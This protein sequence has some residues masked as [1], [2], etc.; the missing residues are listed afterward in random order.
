[1][2]NDEINNMESDESY[3]VSDFQLTTTPNDFNISTIISFIN[4]SVFKIPAFQRHYVWDIK[5][6]SKLIESLLIGLPIPQIFLY[7]N[8][9]NEFL[10]IDG[11][12]RLMTLYYFFNGRFPRKE[13]RAELRNIFDKF[14]MIPKDVM[15][16]DRYFQK[17][18]LKLESPIDGRKNRFDGLNYQTLGE[19]KL[20]LDLSTIRNMVIKPLGDDDEG[21]AKFEIFNRLNSGGMNLTPQEIRMS[22]YHSS[23]NNALLEMNTNRKWRDFLGK[24][25]EDLRLSDV[26]HILRLFAMLCHQDNYKNSISGF[27]NSFS[28]SAR[29][30]S[31]I[32]INLLKDIWNGFMHAC[33]D[34][35]EQDLTTGGNRISITLLESIFFAACKK[36]YVDK[37]VKIKDI[38]KEYVKNLKE[39]ILFI[40]NSTDK[41]TKRESVN[42]RTTIAYLLFEEI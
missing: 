7:Q 23:F 5:R 29:S 37:D 11:Q 30:F 33:R 9:R 1:M 27:L 16:D 19:Y 42:N 39:N 12:Q 24:P 18:N 3:P 36:S 31:E 34:L 25:N 2:F 35:T 10:V 15:A 38:S 21:L 6:A 28:N 8:G 14:G 13:T 17:F 40:A 22:L 20:S 26:E 4:S 41:T 32:D